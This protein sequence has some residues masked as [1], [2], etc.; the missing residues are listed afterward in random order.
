[1]VIQCANSLKLLMIVLLYGGTVVQ[2]LLSFL[3]HTHLL[4]TEVTRCLG[5][6]LTEVTELL[7]TYIC[8]EVGGG[9]DPKKERLGVKKELDVL[10]LTVV[11]SIK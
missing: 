10:V 5:P 8:E 11:H 9:I 1:M 7:L 2:L 3:S 4:L 6:L